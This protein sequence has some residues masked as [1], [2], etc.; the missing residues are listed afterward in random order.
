MTPITEDAIREQHAEFERP[1]IKVLQEA[2]D[3][4]ALSSR[5]VDLELRTHDNT[6]RFGVV[7]D[8][9]FGSLYETVVEMK[10][11]YAI[12][13]A[14]GIHDVLHAGD[15][16]DGHGVYRG[17][18]FELHKVGFDA[19]LDWFK[20]VTAD[21]DA[22]DID[23]YFITGNHDGSFGSRVGVDV[24]AA[25]SARN[26]R[27]HCLGRDSGRIRLSTPDGRH[28]DVMLLHPGGGTA[29]ALSYRVQKTIEQLEGGTKPQ[30]LILGH[31]HKAEYIPSYR[32]IAGLQAGCLQRQTPF[33]V[34]QS[35]SAHVGGWIIE[36]TPGRGADQL[37]NR[38]RA[39]F[40]SFYLD[41]KNCDADEAG[42][43]C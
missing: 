7:T 18:E 39:E 40:I 6:I 36:V 43:P 32:N 9:Q 35:I 29:Y 1:K 37:W 5:P 33:M 27:W 15:V 26:P 41:A 3:A 22:N 17:H 34:R 13:A 4:V 19:Q 12:F 31:Y 8:T 23:T 2:L 42:T 28:Y 10:A 38:T 14:E 21:D 11:L 30:M 16:L 20:H 24:G 25:I